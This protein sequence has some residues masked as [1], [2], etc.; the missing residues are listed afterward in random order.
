MSLGAARSTLRTPRVIARP[1]PMQWEKKR[2]DEVFNVQIIGLMQIRHCKVAR[3]ER[4]DFHNRRS[5]TC[6]G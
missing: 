6:G 5:P 4:P 2:K 1:E 3:L